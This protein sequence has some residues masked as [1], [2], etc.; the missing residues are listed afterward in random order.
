MTQG[1]TPAISPAQTAWAPCPHCRSQAG[2]EPSRT[3]RWICAVCGA[4]IVPSSAGEAR[5]AAELADLVRA[6]RAGAMAMGWG[7]AAV[8]LGSTAMM[9]LVVAAIVLRVSH[10]AAAGLG[11]LA[12]LGALLVALCVSRSRAAARERT[13]R[14]DAAWGIVA[15]E[16]VRA[17]GGAMT[18][19]ELARTIGT[20]EGHA[21]AL[22]ALEEAEAVASSGH[23]R[24]EP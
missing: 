7:A 5:S 2:A 8:A 6:Q 21:E 24:L 1:G 15:G 18:A 16:L 13:A 17:R 4:P 22:L 19:R 9:A 23:Q 12:A 14:L 11:A 10:T 20:D 3:L